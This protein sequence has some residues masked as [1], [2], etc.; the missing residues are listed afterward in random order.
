MAIS[1]KGL[2]KITVDG[3]VF[4]WRIRKKI[5][6][7]EKHNDQYGIPVFHENGGQLIFIFPGFCRSRGYGRKSF[8]SVTP[9]II[10][11][12][13]ERAIKSGWNF[14]MPGKPISL[15]KDQLSTDTKTSKWIPD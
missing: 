4:Y 3:E 6:H 13:I 12:Q 7:D 5:S 11:Q 1:K 15:V 14:R 9:A 8:Q 10:R 2:R